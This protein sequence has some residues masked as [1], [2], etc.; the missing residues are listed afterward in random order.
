MSKGWRFAGAII[1]ALALTVAAPAGAGQAGGGLDFSG[2]VPLLPPSA[3]TGKPSV[4]PPAGALP[5]ESGPCVPELPCGSRL[6]GS[7]RKNGAVELQVP[8]LR[9]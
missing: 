2:T 1:G 8:A 6:L 3:A 7:V 5:G 9:W 4:R